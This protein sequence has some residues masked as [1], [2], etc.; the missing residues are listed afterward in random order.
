LLIE[1]Y[2]LYKGT[3]DK[4]RII[5]NMKDE[6]KH[7]IDLSEKLSF[8]RMFDVMDSKKIKNIEVNLN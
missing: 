2:R 4:G 1:K 5:I 6:K 7:E 8:E 3:S